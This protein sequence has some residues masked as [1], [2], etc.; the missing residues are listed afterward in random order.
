MTVDECREAL[1]NNQPVT[2]LAALIEV[3]V[4]DARGLDRERYL[5]DH[6]TWHS[7]GY[8]ASTDLHAC[9]VCDAG[10]VIAGTLEGRPYSHYY[11]VD[12][13]DNTYIA[14]IALDE[15]RRGLVGSALWRLDARSASPAARPSARSG[16]SRQTYHAWPTLART[17]NYTEWSDFDAHLDALARLAVELRRT[18]AK[19]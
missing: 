6:S 11:P 18:E 9:C 7:P 17:A 15:V 2:S 8:R 13:G 14:L 16:N 4:A 3:A 10:A 5:P 1:R 19:S 12:Y